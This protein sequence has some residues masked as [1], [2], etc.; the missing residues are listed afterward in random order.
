[1]ESITKNPDLKHIAED[2]FECL[3]KKSLIACRSVNK[4]WKDILNQPMFYLRNMKATKYT[5]DNVKIWKN[6]ARKLASE[7]AIMSNFSHIGVFLGFKVQKTD[8]DDIEEDLAL[9]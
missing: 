5:D 4:S 6:L 7:R 9:V 3:D 8:G 1:M 2:I